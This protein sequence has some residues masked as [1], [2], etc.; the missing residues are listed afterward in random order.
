MNIFQSI[1]GYLNSVPQGI[2]FNLFTCGAAKSGKNYT[3][4][5]MANKKKER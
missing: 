3:M 2:N 1:Q 5:G 4:F